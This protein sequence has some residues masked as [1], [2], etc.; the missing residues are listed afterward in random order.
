MIR[1]PP[2]STRTDT[3]FPYT[4]LFRSLETRYFRLDAQIQFIHSMTCFGCATFM[5]LGAR[6]ARFAPGSFLIG[7]F[8]LTGSPYLAPYYLGPSQFARV[9]IGSEGLLCAWNVRYPSAGLINRCGPQLQ[10]KA[11][12]KPG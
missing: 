3:L 7:S 9:C 10:T 12:R 6:K 2:R 5:N 4:T 11:G 8:P 1:R